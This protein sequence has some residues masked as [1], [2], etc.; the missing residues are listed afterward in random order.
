MEKGE[1]ELHIEWPSA[2]AS[3]KNALNVTMFY[4][5]FMLKSSC[6]NHPGAVLEMTGNCEV[7]FVYIFP[8]NTKDNRRWIDGI[9]HSDVISP[10][11]D[12]HGLPPAL[13]LSYNLF[14]MVTSSIHH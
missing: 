3:V 4:Q 1:L 14:L 9:I 6:K 13:S 5:M 10:C 7:E 8:A 12:L 2:L 11:K